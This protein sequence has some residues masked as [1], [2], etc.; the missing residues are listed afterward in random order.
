MLKFKTSW[1]HS[2]IQFMS[3]VC[4]V[5]ERRTGSGWS[6]ASFKISSA[7]MAAGSYLTE[8]VHPSKASVCVCYC[9]SVR[10]YVQHQHNKSRYIFLLSH[11]VGL[12]LNKQKTQLKTTRSFWTGVCN[13]SGRWNRSPCTSGAHSLLSG[14]VK[15][16]QA[17]WSYKCSNTNRSAWQTEI[18]N[19]WRLSCCGTR[20]ASAKTHLVL[21]WYIMDIYWSDWVF[22]S[23]YK[24]AFVN[25]TPTKCN[26]ALN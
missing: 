20:L 21:Y 3:V 19:I 9:W 12:T 6:A 5:S 18:K 14:E 15:S 25:Q 11:S 23:L 1:G 17:W 8:A 7:T 22:S 13:P 24:A 4:M 26:L 2:P 16:I 10:H